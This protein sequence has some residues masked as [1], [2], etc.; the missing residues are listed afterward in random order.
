MKTLALTLLM[1]LTAHEAQGQIFGPRPEPTQGFSQNSISNMG[2]IGDTLWVGPLLN[3]EIGRNGIFVIPEKADSIVKGNGR[4]FSIALAPDTVFAGIAW[5]KPVAGNNVQTAIGFYLSTDGGDEW[6]FIPPPLDDPDQRKLRYGSDS[7]TVLPI[8]VPEQSPAYNV[9]L[10]GDVLLAA[11]WASGIRR[12][13]DFGRTWERIILP[14]FELDSLSPD[15]SYD[16]VFDPRVP[17]AGSANLPKYPDAWQNFLGFSVMIDRTG[18][19]WAGTAG[20]INIS[21]NALTEAPD[22]VRWRHVRAGSTASTMMGNW[23]IRMRQNPADGRVW[24]TNWITNPGERQGLVST[25]DGGRTFRRHLTDERINDIGF[26][27]S[28]I[29]VVGETDLYISRDNGNTWEQQTDIRSATARLRRDASFRSIAAGR[30]VVHI[31][32]SDGLLSTTDTGISWEIRRVDYPFTGGNQFSPTEERSTQ[33]AY[34]NPFSRTQHGVVRIRFSADGDR[35]VRVQ[36]MDFSMVP[37]RTLTGRT[38]A[39]GVYEAEWDGLDGSGRHAANGPVFYR[40]SGGGEALTGK[41]MILD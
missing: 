11:A 33:Y 17:Q 14:P 15:R 6:T 37:F 40:I 28:V 36:L 7:I 13:R 5:S 27:G 1:G 12:S 9:A 4:L 34:P 35:Q 26:D 30:G 10:R 19:V 32:S 23:V 2:A 38:V 31:G 41:I 39:P 29:F 20:G 25:D 16:F 8:V 3:R 24:L 18:H 22:Q 21:D